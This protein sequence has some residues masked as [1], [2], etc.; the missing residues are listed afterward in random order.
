MRSGWAR[1]TGAPFPLELSPR[2]DV[3]RY[4]M[5]ATG[6]RLTS[7]AEAATLREFRADDRRRFFR[8]EDKRQVEAAIEE[9]LS[10]G[11]PV[12]GYQSSSDQAGSVFLFLRRGIRLY[13]GGRIPIAFEVVFGTGDC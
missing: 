5:S 1:A 4:A 13:A 9:I 3:V 6:E 12:A 2:G 8:G 7:K 10:S 11:R